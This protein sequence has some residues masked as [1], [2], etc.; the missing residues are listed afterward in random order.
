MQADGR[1]LSLF[2][3]EKGQTA[4]TLGRPIASSYR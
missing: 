4:G 1:P 2:G 3:G